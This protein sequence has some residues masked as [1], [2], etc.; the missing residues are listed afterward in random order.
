MPSVPSDSDRAALVALHNATDG[1][2]WT[3]NTNWLRDAPNGEW[4]GVTADANGRVTELNLS[5]NNLT[6]SIPA[7]LG[8][9]DNLEALVFAYNSLTG[10]IPS[11][12]GNLGNLRLLELAHNSLTGPIPSELGSLD[13]LGTLWLAHNSLTG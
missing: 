1:P 13:N 4:F 2:N 3:N 12:L 10:S 6:G 11:E 7:E 9:L 5:D 8:N